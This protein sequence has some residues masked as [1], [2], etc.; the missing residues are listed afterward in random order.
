VAFALTFVGALGVLAMLVAWAMA[1][2]VLANGHGGRPTRALAILLFMD[3]TGA[4]LGNGLMF[5]TSSP[6]DAYAFQ[7]L[8]I[9]PYSFLPLVYGSFVSTLDSPL[10]RPLRTRAFRAAAGAIGGAAILLMVLR[11]RLVVSDLVEPWYAPYD[12]VIGPSFYVFFGLIGILCAYGTVVALSTLLRAPR[13]SAARARARAY[14]AAFAARDAGFILVLLLPL[15]DLAL[16]AT[17]YTDLGF[18]N[19]VSGTAIVLIYVPLLAYG[20]LRT[21]LFDVDLRIKKGISRGTVSVVFLAFFLVVSQVAQNY[22]SAA[23]GYLVGGVATALLLLALTPVQRFA[24]RVANVTMPHVRPTEEYFAFRKHE[25][26]RQALLDAMQDGV[27]TARERAV[28]DGLRRSLG[29]DPAVAQ[30]MERAAGAA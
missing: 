11:P 18:E 5:L 2:L 23:Y 28:L 25:I 6:A 13:G 27:V 14:T 8:A 12:Q 15:V 21:Q 16:P 4:G 1:A 29:I 30:E 7:A 19:A 26:Y 17:R 9:L 22:L 10:A 20:I 3:G 24:E